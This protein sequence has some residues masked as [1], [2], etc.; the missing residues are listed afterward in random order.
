MSQGLHITLLGAPQI[1]LDGRS[2]HFRSIKATALLAYLATTGRPHGRA[3]LAALFW[4]ESDKKRARG[5]LRFTLSLLKKELGDAYLHITRQQLELNPDANWQADVV[6]VRHLL[7]PALNGKQ[8]LTEEELH[9]VA[10]G[11][12]LY[13]AEFLQGFHL[14]DSE[15]FNEWAFLYR[16]AVQREAATAL[17]RITAVYAQKEQWDTAVS[18]AHRWLNLDALHEPAHCQLMSLYAALGNWTAVQNQYQSLTDLLEQELSTSP[19]PETTAHYEQ[20]TAVATTATA[21]TPDQRSRHV[22][23][24]KVRRFWVDGLLRPLHQEHSYIQLGL[25]NVNQHIA[26]PWADVIDTAQ[27]PQT[28]NIHDAFHNADRALLILGSPGAGKTITLIE[29]SSRLLT[30]ATDSETQPVPVILNLSSWTEE[31][32]EID[33]WAVEEMVA[34]YQI[35]RR[36]GRKWLTKDHLLLMLDG[37]DEMPDTHHTACIAAINRFRQTHGLPDLVVCCRRTAYEA[38]TKT[39]GNRLELNGA[40]LIQPL[41]TAQIRHHLPTSL[42]HTVFQDE[43]LLDMAQTPLN[44]N[45]MCTSFASHGQPNPNEDSPPLTH[46]H[47]FGLYV[48]R[49]FARQSAKGHTAYNQNRLREELTWLAQQMWRHNQSVF[50]LEQIQPSWLA[51]RYQWLYLFASHAIL[52]AVL[53]TLVMWSFI[54]LIGVNPPHV[55]VHFLTA[56]ATLWGVT[57]SWLSQLWT[58]F[59][60]NLFAG[61]VSTAVNGLFFFWRRRRGDEAQINRRLGWLQTI[62]VACVA[63]LAVAVPLAV[64][65]ALTMALFLGGMA[66]TGSLLVFGGYSHGQSF[67]T[68]IRLRGALKWTWRNAFVLAGLGASLSLLWSAIIWLTDPTAVS[69]GLNAFNMGLLFF[70]LGGLSGRQPQLKNRPNEGIHIAG[71]NGLQAGLVVALPAVLFTAVTVNFA[72]GVY[73]GLMLGILAGT[74]HG[75]TDVIKHYIVRGL[76]W[77]QRGTPLNYVGLL[78]EAANCIL[79]QKIGGGYVFRHRLLQEYF[80]QDSRVEAHSPKR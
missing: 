33:V 70:L 26:H 73:T 20:L 2:L 41:T 68:E 45:M 76:L 13:R 22:L 5:A 60:L 63:G 16:E 40:I 46:Q 79:L 80:G 9:D 47:L 28:A 25:E 69:A 34:K 50:L 62:V 27:V 11:V 38:A 21:V 6:T 23:I 49:M 57:S 30:L 19:H 59:G 18:Y 74:V 14:A 10:Q 51:S 3:E 72:S 4:P 71:R 35:P 12:A 53:G 8:A 32:Q 61:M 65:D 64:T 1:V 39:E 7:T 17:K 42:A 66:A 78:D 48:Q 15:P 44:L 37:L 77:H 56:F 58:L 54:Q 43:L 75:F 29:L 36:I 67:R 31:Q 52:P 55:E 24:E